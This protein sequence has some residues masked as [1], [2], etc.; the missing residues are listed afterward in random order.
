MPDPSAILGTLQFVGVAAKAVCEAVDVAI[1]FEQEEQHILKDLRK[2][3]DS[4]KSDILVYKV[5]LNAMESDTG[6][7]PYTSFIQ[8][9]VMGCARAHRLTELMIHPITG[10]MERGQ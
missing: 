7:P 4:L 6:H 3:V 5:L 1:E 2:G 10:R 8:R 9:Y